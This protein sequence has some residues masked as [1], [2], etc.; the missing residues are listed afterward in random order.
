MV[1][2]ADA[3]RRVADTGPGLGATGRG[4]TAR[5]KAVRD[6]IAPEF[7]KSGYGDVTTEIAPLT[8]FYAA[9]A[10]HQQYLDANPF[11]YCPVHS[12]GVTCN[13]PS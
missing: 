11:G 12:T 5:A 7:A 6:S 10:G 4:Q 2:G 8:E 3:V 1:T 9:E 13:P